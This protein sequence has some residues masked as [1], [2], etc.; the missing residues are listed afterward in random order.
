MKLRII[1]ISRWMDEMDDGHTDSVRDSLFS[2]SGECKSSFCRYKVFLYV[3][4]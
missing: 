4:R 3:G 1:S 2:L